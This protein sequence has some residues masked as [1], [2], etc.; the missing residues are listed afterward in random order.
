MTPAHGALQ[1]LCQLSFSMLLQERD[2]P[3]MHIPWHPSSVTKKLIEMIPL[4]L[5]RGGQQRQVIK[6]LIAIRQ[7]L[8]SASQLANNGRSQACVARRPRQRGQVSTA[9][10]CAGL[11]FAAKKPSGGVIVSM[12]D[13][14]E[15]R[16]LILL[17]SRPSRS[18]PKTA[19]AAPSP[20]TA[21]SLPTPR[22][23]QP[24]SQEA[25]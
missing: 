14:S 7:C 17:R 1:R 11:G 9:N 25:P 10:F 18:L 12:S 13:T 19:P 20:Q 6:E 24:K 8:I 15:H 2:N 23:H 3:L 22:D 5:K 16:P 21:I 4:R